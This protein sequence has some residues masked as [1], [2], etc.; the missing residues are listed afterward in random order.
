MQQSTISELRAGITHIDHEILSLLTRRME[1]A[2]DIA[3]YKKERSLPI[4]D[5]TRE[6]EIIETYSAIVDFDIRDIYTAIMQES[7][8]I[9]K[10]HLDL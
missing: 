8:N 4:F 5:P 6:Q 3:L 7:K 2:R 1:I 10:R 9:Q